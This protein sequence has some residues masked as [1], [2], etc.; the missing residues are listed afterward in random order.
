MRFMVFYPVLF[1]AIGRYV[2]PALEEP[3]GFQVD[4]LA[5]YILAA[6][7]LITPMI[8]GA[9]IGFSILDDRD[10]HIL[11]SIK[12]TPLSIHQFLSFRIAMVLVF[13]FAACIFVLWFSN[14]GGLSWGDKIVVAFLATLSAPMTGFLINALSKNKIEGFAVM[15]GLGMVVVVPVVAVYFTDATELFFS[16]IPGFW[17]AKVISSAVRT[18]E[19]MYLN[20]RLYFSIGLI[21]ALILNLL[22]YRF[23]LRR[24]E[25]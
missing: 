24:A 7:A 3:A 16:V 10:D 1:G 15:K 20:Y 4:L 22:V 9:V 18:D 19:M 14:I 6:L 13:S 12:V 25:F 17:P 11:S 21:Y 5:D 2:L 8:Y 23:F